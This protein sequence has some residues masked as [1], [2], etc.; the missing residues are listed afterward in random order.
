M[1]ALKTAP[2][3]EAHVVQSM[4][5]EPKVEESKEPK[6]ETKVEAK[7]EQKDPEGKEEAKEATEE[8]KVEPKV[9]QPPKVKD[10]KESEPEPSQPSQP[11]KG[12]LD[13]FSAGPT[14]WSNVKHH[15]F[16]S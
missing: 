8:P 6:A 3:E 9:D 10:L 5:P 16:G 1:K 15:L 12:C 14:R 4:L 11:H 13:F 7:I 2:S